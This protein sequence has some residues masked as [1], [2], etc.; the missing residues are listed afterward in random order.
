[1]QIYYIAECPASFHHHITQLSCIVRA[2][3]HVFMR[4]RTSC[5]GRTSGYDRNKPDNL[6]VNVE[7]NPDGYNRLLSW[8]FREF[9]ATIKT[10]YIN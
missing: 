6:T 1:M 8:K 9:L 10:I 4:F 2:Q 3:Y 7:A 5:N